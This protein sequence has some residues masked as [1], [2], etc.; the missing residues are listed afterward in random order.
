MKARNINFKDHSIQFNESEDI[1]IDLP[2]ESATF[3]LKDKPT[4]KN[5]TGETV[6]EVSGLATD[7]R[8][9]RSWAI[10][11][12]EPNG[13][14]NLHFH[15][16]RTENYY[17][18]NGK[19]LIILGEESHVLSQG[20]SIEIPPKTQHQVFNIGEENL[21]II[22]RCSP[23]WIFADSHSVTEVSEKVLQI[24]QSLNKFSDQK[25]VEGQNRV[26]QVTHFKSAPKKNE[27]E[28]NDTTGLTMHK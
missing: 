5:S 13:H 23:S 7:E 14:S 27:D 17:I 1:I 9:D 18:T 4:F 25:N 15:E 10:A 20:E 3:N 6:I 2:G 21:E 12:F 26:H 16:N 11:F 28:V 19:A 8:E 22:V 24:Q